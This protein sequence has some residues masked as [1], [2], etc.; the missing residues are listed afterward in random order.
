MDYFCNKRGILFD[1]RSIA[2]EEL[3]EHSVRCLIEVGECIGSPFE[4]LKP[5]DGG[6]SSAYSRGT[7]W[8]IPRK[9]VS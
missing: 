2:T 6:N 9:P 4:V 5:P 3:F 7:D 8:M 1:D